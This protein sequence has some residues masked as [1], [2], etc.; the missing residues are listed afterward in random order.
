MVSESSQSCSTVLLINGPDQ[1]FEYIACGAQAQTDTLFPA[2]NAARTTAASSTSTSVPS[3]SLTSPA[4]RPTATVVETSSVPLSS[5]STLMDS[6]FVS[7]TSSPGS[8]ALKPEPMNLGAIV[9]GAIGGLIVICLTILGIVLIRRKRGVKGQ[10][11]MP[12]GRTNYGRNEFA[13]DVP[14]HAHS[15]VDLKKNNH[16]DSRHGPVEMYSGHHVNTEPVELSGQGHYV[17]TPKA[18]E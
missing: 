1:S 9:G 11:T 2:P 7:P 13:D 4:S 12:P 10:E 16:W 8:T 3:S 6:P 18:I 17:N 5:S 14:L 15:L